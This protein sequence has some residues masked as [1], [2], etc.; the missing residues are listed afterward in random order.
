MKSLRV[1]AAASLLLSLP[2][3]SAAEPDRNKIPGAARPLPLTAVRLT[4]GPLKN[5]QDL[6]AKY[7]LALEPDRMLAGYRQRVGWEPKAKGY[8]GWDSVNGKQLTGHIAGHYLSGVSLMYAAT[9]DARFQERADDIVKELKEVQ[10]KRGNGYLGALTDQ[11]GTDAATIFEQ[12]S[13]GDIRSGGF[14]LNGMWS[15][16]YTLHK[17]YAGLRDAYR[18]AGNKTALELEIK[19]AA[20]AA[21]IVG[22][23]NEA[24]IQRMLNTIR[25]LPPKE[26]MALHLFYLSEQP[27]ELARQTLGLSGRVDGSDSPVGGSVASGPYLRNRQ[28]QHLCQ[29]PDCG[30]RFR[31]TAFR[32]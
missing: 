7:L 3:V 12:V 15:P 29:L 5:A 1:L 11:Q 23:L 32:F 14:D 25:Q 10:D 22:K 2:T 28:I 8:G 30:W 20:W 26:R 13:N 9:G 6:N 19:F 21:G 24:Q 17:T 4:G 27:A 16:W 31:W 18:F